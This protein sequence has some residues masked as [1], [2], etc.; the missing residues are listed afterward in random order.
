MERTWKVS[1]GQVKLRHLPHTLL[2]PRIQAVTTE[3]SN[4]N[5]NCIDLRYEIFQED[6]GF[7]SAVL[8]I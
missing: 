4:V 2:T 1:N 7:S 5:I 8:F 3:I 6:C